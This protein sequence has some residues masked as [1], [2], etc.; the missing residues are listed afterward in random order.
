MDDAGLGIPTFPVTIDRPMIIGPIGVDGANP[1]DAIQLAKHDSTI[2]IGLEVDVVGLS[3]I[4]MLDLKYQGPVQDGFAVSTQSIEK[5]SC[6]RL[7]EMNGLELETAIHL[8]DREGTTAGQVVFR[9]PADVL[10]LGRE[11]Q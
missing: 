7:P 2:L 1:I 10:H 9:R 6:S 3:E 8:V 4:E 11:T 5:I